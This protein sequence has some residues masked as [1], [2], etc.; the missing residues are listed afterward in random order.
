MDSKGWPS[1]LDQIRDLAEMKDLTFH[2]DYSGRGM[3]GRTCLGVS[4]SEAD[5]WQFA[6]YLGNANEGELLDIFSEA[7]S[8]DNL[9]NDRIWYWPNLNVDNLD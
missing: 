8:V 7:P 6:L 4:G 9:G 1:T 2:S 5:L 3:Y